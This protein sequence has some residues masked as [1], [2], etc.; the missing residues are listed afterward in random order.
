MEFLLSKDLIFKFNE[1]SPRVLLSA[2]GVRKISPRTSSFCRLYTFSDPI[3]SLASFTV[4]FENMVLLEYV[5]GLLAIL[6]SNRYSLPLKDLNFQKFIFLFKMDA[7]I[8]KYIGICILQAE[9][10]L[11]LLPLKRQTKNAADDILIFYFYLLKNIRLDFSCES[12]A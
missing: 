5:L 6:A 11:I 9:T 8:V 2:L 3:R 4:T 1:Y 12:S 7:F 10:K